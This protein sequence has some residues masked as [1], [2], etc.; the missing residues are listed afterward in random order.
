MRSTA[1]GGRLDDA[2]G[3]D[4]RHAD[5]WKKNG[6]GSSTRPGSRKRP[7]EN[8]PAGSGSPISSSTPPA[9]ADRASDRPVPGAEMTPGGIHSVLVEH[10][11]LGFSSVR[12]RVVEPSE[13]RVRASAET[14]ASASIHY[15]TTRF[16]LR[17]K[18]FVPAGLVEAEESRPRADGWIA[19]KPGVSG[20]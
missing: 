4:F 14:Y 19:G 15:G 18:S 5:G 2:L 7:V 8:A 3:S 20:A 16:R 6:L 11:A 10:F 17:R 13:P 1:G 9:P 12:V